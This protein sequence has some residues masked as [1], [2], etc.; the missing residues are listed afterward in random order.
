[1]TTVEIEIIDYTISKRSS[2]GTE[3]EIVIQ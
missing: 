1:M 3:K 2:G